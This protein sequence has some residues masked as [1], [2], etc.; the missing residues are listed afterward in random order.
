MAVERKKIPSGY[1]ITNIHTNTSHP[2]VIYA[3]VCSVDGEV[4]CSSTLDYC[5]NRVTGLI[6]G[7]PHNGMCFGVD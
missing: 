4:I 6:T 7:N 5:M 3:D 1:V 2:E